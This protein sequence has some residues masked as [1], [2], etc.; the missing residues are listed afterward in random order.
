MADDSR[1]TH[2]RVL[3]PNGNYTSEIPI[4]VFASNIIYDV[5]DPSYG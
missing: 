4:S 3:L 5:G 1:L 2:L